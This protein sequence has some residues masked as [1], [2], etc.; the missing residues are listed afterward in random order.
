MNNYHFTFLR[1]GESIGN[2]DGIVQGQADFPLSENGVQQVSSLAARWK[3]E[4]RRF[5]G[6]ITSPLNRARQTAEIMAEKLGGEISV[7]SSGEGE[8]T[9]RVV[10]PLSWSHAEGDSPTVEAQRSQPVPEKG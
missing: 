2:R 9:F 6:I 4:N 1:H 10:I 8:T 3:E 7:E 5:D